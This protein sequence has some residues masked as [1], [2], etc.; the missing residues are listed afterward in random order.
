T[1][2]ILSL[3][4][5]LRQALDTGL[6]RQIELGERLFE[7]A[8]LLPERRPLF[9]DLG[10]DGAQ[11]SRLS[12]RF[13][14]HLDDVADFGDGK[15]EP[16]AAQDLP[17]QMT[18]RGPEQTCTSAPDRLDQPLI[19][20]KAQGAGRDAEFPRQFRNRVIFAHGRNPSGPSAP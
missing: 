19:L 12:R 2:R 16:L 4:P 15:A 3:D 11:L 6:L 20:V 14:V 9:L 13:A 18:V 10:D 7:I 17:D 1:T 5:Q 8:A